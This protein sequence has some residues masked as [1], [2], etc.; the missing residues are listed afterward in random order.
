MSLTSQLAAADSPV[1]RFFVDSFPNTSQLVRDGAPALRGDLRSAPLA[2]ALDVNP[3]RAGAAVDYLLRFALA[4]QPCPDS[5]P[6]R[7]GA[8]MLGRRLSVSAMAAVEEA[9]RFV[10]E[11]GPADR[12]VSDD[13]WEDLTRIS[14]L[15]ATYEAVYRSGRPPASFAD[16][17]S[18]PGD[19]KEWATLVCVDVEVEDVAM[20]GWA[21]AE[22]HS[23]LRGRPLT[24]NPTFAQSRALGGADADL[25]TDDGLLI[26]LKST[27]TTRT[28]SNTGLWQLCGY[29]LADS[30]DRFGIAAIGLF[31]L[32]WRTQ[33][34]WPLVELL[35]ALAGHSVDLPEMRKTFADV[36]VVAQE[37]RRDL[38]RERRARRVARADGQARPSG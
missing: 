35:D 15:L 29:A 32:R 33:V 27:S 13:Q 21:A 5:S 19:W 20:L 12:S 4:P 18:L 2:A 26:E 10:D 9:L 14:L 25:I 38:A 36:L 11:V 34:V 30:D 1:R 23:N 3:G 7:L 17:E 31:A 37:R 28:C 6:A 24:C 8:G 16:L 22:D